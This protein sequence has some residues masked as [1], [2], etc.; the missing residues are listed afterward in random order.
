MFAGT[1]VVVSG[2]QRHVPSSDSRGAAT[3]ATASGAGTSCGIVNGAISG[4]GRRVS[5]SGL[6]DV[7]D[8]GLAPDGWILVTERAGRIFR[9][10]VIDV[11]GGLTLGLADPI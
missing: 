4:S 1:P 8:I 7:T 3:P 9:G 11:D 6:D 5:A 2:S 10:T